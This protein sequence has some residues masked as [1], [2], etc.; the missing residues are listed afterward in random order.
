[1]RVG[2]RRLGLVGLMQHRIGAN[3][4]RPFVDAAAIAG[5]PRREFRFTMPSI[6]GRCASGMAAAS[7]LPCA[8]AGSPLSAASRVFTRLSQGASAGESASSDW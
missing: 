8:G 1:M 3:K 4:A 2:E 7:V 6:I 5:E